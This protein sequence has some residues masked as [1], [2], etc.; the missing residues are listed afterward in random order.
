M[1]NAAITATVDSA[2][3][4]LR[5]GKAGEARGWRY[6]EMLIFDDSF[7]HEAWNR[8]LSDRTIILFEIWRPEIPQADREALA[9]LFESIDRV[10]PALGQEA[11]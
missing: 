8:G 3:Q 7:E 4:L 2:T 6:G 11:A 10:D 9:I 5:A 1:R